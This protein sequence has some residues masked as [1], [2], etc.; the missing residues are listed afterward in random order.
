MFEKPKSYQTPWAKWN[1]DG[2]DEADDFVKTKGKSIIQTKSV[3]D[4]NYYRSRLTEA[5]EDFKNLFPKDLT[6]TECAKM[7]DGEIHE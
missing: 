6:G 3:N 4:L 5:L 7:K 2:I 1:S